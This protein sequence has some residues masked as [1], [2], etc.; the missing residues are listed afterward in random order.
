M[1]NKL[2]LRSGAGSIVQK[3]LSM[4]QPVAIWRA[5]SF[6]LISTEAFDL[7]DGC[8]FH[9]AWKAPPGVS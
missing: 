2:I 5:K 1:S 9:R 6:F 4:V 3:R 7:R 8:A